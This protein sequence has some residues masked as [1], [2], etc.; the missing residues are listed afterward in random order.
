M[1]TAFLSGP[2]SPVW[3]SCIV[4]NIMNLKEWGLCNRVT[5]G[6]LQKIFL[7]HHSD[8]TWGSWYLKLLVTPLFV[9]QILHADIKKRHELQ[10][11]FCACTQPM[12]DDTTL[13]H[14][15]SLVGHIHKM[16]PGPLFTK[17]TPSYGYRD[18][19]YKPKTVWR[20]SQVYNGNPYTDKTASS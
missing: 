14:H 20:P 17:K 19:H 16:I 6:R 3:Q 7:G 1:T 12:R 4:N 13:Y 5:W 18:P 9:Q 10:G 15:L 2:D 11:S 8:I